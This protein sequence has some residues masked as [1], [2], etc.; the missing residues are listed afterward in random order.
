MAEI[1]KKRRVRKVETL[2]QQTVKANEAKQPRRRVRNTAKKA[3]KPLRAL[4]FLRY[5]VP[6]YFRNSWRELKEVKWPGRKETAQLTLAVFTFAIIFGLI[7]TIT[8][9]GLDK[10]FKRILLKL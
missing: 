6:P 5:L 1:K 9:Y 4:R 10:V 7:V 2:R 3:V 8:D